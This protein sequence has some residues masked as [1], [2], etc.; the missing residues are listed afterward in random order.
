M[1]I[2]LSNEKLIFSANNLE[3]IN[4]DKENKRIFRDNVNIQKQ[5]LY[6]FAD[7]ATHYPDSF[8]IYLRGNV[9]MYGEYDSLFCDELILFD[10]DLRKF[11]AQGNI[12]FFK[13]G[14]MSRE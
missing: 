8:K 1:T 11:Q 9:Q 13:L 7:I 3:T 2:L 6:L 5:G 12:H 14:N 10:Q 4:N